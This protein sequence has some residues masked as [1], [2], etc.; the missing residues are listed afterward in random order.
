MEK[1]ILSNILS[2][3]NLKTIFSYEDY[4]FVLRLIKYNKSIQDKLEI[5]DQNYND[6]INYKYIIKNA[7][8]IISE[9][10]KFFQ[11]D[12]H[13]MFFTFLVYIILYGLTLANIK[14]I[15]YTIFFLV[16]FIISTIES[17]K[18][19]R[20]EV[21]KLIISIIE[22]K[23][24]IFNLC[25]SFALPIL[26]RIIASKEP[27]GDESSLKIIKYVNLNVITFFLLNAGY[28]FI[29]YN[30]RFNEYAKLR[31]IVVILSILIDCSYEIAI[32]YKIY[33]LFS[34][35]KYISYFYLF[36]FLFFFLNHISIVLKIYIFQLFYGIIKKLRNYTTFLLEYKNIKIHEYLV[37]N[38]FIKMKNKRAFL[39]SKAKYFL[40]KHSPEEKKLFSFLNELR[41]N[42]LVGELLLDINFPDFLINELSEVMLFNNKNIF[43]LDKEHYLFRY[44][45]GGFIQHAKDNENILIKKNLK[46][47]NIIIRNEI[48]Y[49]LIYENQ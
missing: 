24:Y 44:K 23:G 9:L 7:F 29:M 36:D 40:I 11:R 22:L 25:F 43:I 6:H 10:N 8:I 21:N 4:N 20:A 30:P 33:L 38:D 13:I 37:P 5:T 45:V 17:E 49:I 12:E 28:S 16:I 26:S 2:N 15:Y 27:R 41:K 46:R 48:E 39:I 1:N 34:L 35:N 19:I 47:I 42:N 18:T 32:V 14:L 31:L 3:Y